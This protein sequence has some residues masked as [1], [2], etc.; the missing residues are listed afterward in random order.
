VT[1]RTRRRSPWP[2]VLAC[3]ALGAAA[4]WAWALNLT[5]GP[6]SGDIVGSDSLALQAAVDRV[7]RDGSGTVLVRPGTYTMLDALHLRSGVRVKG[8]G[9]P[10]VLQNADSLAAPLAEDAGHGAD[11]IL[12]TDA[13]GFLKGMGVAF[14]DDQHSAGWYVNCRSIISVEGDT[15]VLDEPLDLDFL[16]SRN[17]RVLA[18]HSVVSA[19][20]VRNAGLENLILDGSRG[21]NL[22]LDGFRGGAA[23]LWRCDGCTLTNCTVR[24]FDGDGIS[25]QVSSNITL[26]RCQVFRNAGSGIHLGS[27][28]NA[29]EVSECEVHDNA[30]NGILLWWRVT[31]SRF[32]DNTVEG[33]GLD[34]VSLGHQDN[35]N[36]LVIN[37]I[38]RNGRHGI[39]FREEVEVHA[40]AR[41]V[42]QDNIIRDNGQDQP[43][44]G[45]HLCGIQRDITISGNTIEDTLQ[46]GRVTQRNGIV[47]EAGVDGVKTRGNVIRGHSGEMV[48]DGSGGTRNSLQ[49]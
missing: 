32:T 12:L 10:P 21:T 7:A 25:A 16:I 3:L 23:Y 5:V 34:G 42:L 43:G 39:Y 20:Q 29:V 48:V 41:N 45:I 44:D 38:R 8:V 6:Q 36:L 19:R 15:L 22:A 33:N 18:A 31:G 14:T 47:L 35:D 30:L 13:S 27:G 17:A 46:D 28:S 11:R 9:A 26:S 24:N 2:G 49:F 4:P 1:A 37:K 40:A